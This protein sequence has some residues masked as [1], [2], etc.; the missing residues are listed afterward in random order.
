MQRLKF[1]AVV[2]QV[3]AVV[4]AKWDIHQQVEVMDKSRQK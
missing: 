1:G 3:T 2:P 4:V